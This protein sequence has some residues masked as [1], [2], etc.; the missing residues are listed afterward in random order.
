MF[1]ASRGFSRQL[2]ADVQN[3][4]RI[5]PGKYDRTEFDPVHCFAEWALRFEGGS[6]YATLSERSR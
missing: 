2:C 6:T 1:Q 5:R 4:F 3:S